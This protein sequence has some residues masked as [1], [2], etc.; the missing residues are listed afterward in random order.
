V[1]RKQI[2][3]RFGRHDRVVLANELIEAIAS[4]GR[5]FF[6]YED[7]VAWIERDRRGL[8]F[9][10]NEWSQKRIYISRRG[11][12]RGF[13]HGGTMH[14]L[15]EDLVE[16]IR[17]GKQLRESTFEPRWGYDDEMASVVEAGKRI[18]VI[19]NGSAEP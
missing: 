10:H 16:F 5:K 6:R 4:C 7:R 17:T 8:L 18:G 2:E 1:N 15:I 19:K 13:H 9:L 3:K 14:C 11:V 12:W